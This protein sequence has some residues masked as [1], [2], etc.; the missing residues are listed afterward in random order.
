MMNKKISEM[1]KVILKKKCAYFSVII[2]ICLL[3]SIPFNFTLSRAETKSGS[4]TLTPFIGGYIFEGNQNYKNGLTYGLGLGY[5]FDKNWCGEAIFSY[6]DT[7]SE[8]DGHNM[9]AYLHHLD[10]LYHFMPSQKLIPY[11]AAGIGNF[12][13]DNKKWTSNMDFLVNYGTGL[14]Y[15]FNKSLALRGDIRHL[16]SF[17][18]DK[19]KNN[20][21]CTVGLSYCFGGEKK[22]VIPPPLPED[23][24][25]DGVY[26]NVDKCP[27]TPAGIPVNSFG[28]PV[29][30]DSDGVPDYK[31]KC[32]DTPKGVLVEE[33]GCPRD[34]D[35]DTIPDYRDKCPK[36]P[37][38]VSVDES[39]CPKDSDGDG[40]YDYQDRCPETSAGIMVDNSGCPKDSD[41]DTIPDYQDNCPGTASG[42]S[43]DEAGCPKDSDGDGVY[44]YQDRC[45]ETS[46]G[47]M[48]DNSGCPKDSDYDGVQ[49][50]QDNCPGTASSVPVDDAGCPKDSDGDGIYDYLDGCPETP[51]N[52]RVNRKGCWVLE[53]LEF[54]TNKWEIK[55]QSYPLLDE[56]VA[57]FKSNTALRV[58]IQGHTDN[59]GKESYNMKLSKNRARAVMEYLVMKGISASQL[60]IVGY[61]PLKPIAS[62][63]TPEGRAQN[64]RVELVLLR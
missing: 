29:D 57:V 20:L 36:T 50:Y 35:G 44:D 13:R 54:D 41:G 10:G 62:N 11:L 43:A 38:T 2:L 31:D 6:I 8:I 3:S 49:D 1:S 42:V 60:S 53:N 39:G 33:A 34:N 24:D 40:V 19:K 59:I 15:F 32:T 58:A 47:I 23:R 25:G 27:G 64:R 14:K 52:A 18:V 63:D 7:E 22:K 17:N 55:P 21:S 37:G 30:S 51:Q 26:D 4:F 9:D 61:G 46:A 56:I 5:N 45:P 28:C 12:P 16:I 48:V